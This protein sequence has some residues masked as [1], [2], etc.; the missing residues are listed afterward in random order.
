ME[1]LNPKFALYDSKKLC[2]WTDTLFISLSE[3]DTRAVTLYL[4]SPPHSLPHY[5][6]A[7]FPSSLYTSTLGF[8]L[9]RLTHCVYKRDIEAEIVII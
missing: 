2:A 6:T 5:V 3:V 1:S 7:S 9:L 8:I 4:P